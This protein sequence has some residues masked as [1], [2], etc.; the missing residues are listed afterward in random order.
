MSSIKTYKD[1]SFKIIKSGNITELYSYQANLVKKIKKDVDLEVEK[2]Y[3][4]IVAKK[5][6]PL[7]QTKSSE[8]IEYFRRKSDISFAKRKLRRLI[9]S[10]IGQYDEVDKFVTLTFAGENPTRE[11][12]VKEY[13]EFKRRLKYYYGDDIYCL[14]VIERGEKGTKRLHLHIVFFGLK[15]IKHTDLLKIWNNGR[16]NIKKINSMGDVADYMTKYIGKTLEDSFIEKG[17]RF[18]FPSTNLKKP[19]EEFLNDSEIHDYINTVDLGNPIYQFSFD[20]PF[21][22]LC[23]YTKFKKM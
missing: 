10:N 11:K 2:E 5:I 3:L 20:S 16:V 19:Q 7:I 13:Q 12:V 15:F 8:S 4:R 14:A 1:Y 21:V 17:Q 6:K 18:Y 23:D 22:G 9:Y